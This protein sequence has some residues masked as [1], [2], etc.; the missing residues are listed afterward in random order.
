MME[1]QNQEKAT[2][3]QHVTVADAA[4]PETGNGKKEDKGGGKKEKKT[5]KPLT[6]KQ[7]QQRK[8]LM[9]YPLMGLLFLGS[10]WLIFAPS[11]KRDVNRDTVGAFN[12]DIPL[13][14]NDGIIGDKRKAYEQAQAEKQQAEK[15]RSLEDFAF[16]EES[17]TDG[18]EMELPDSEPEREPFR[19]YSDNGG[20]LVLRGTEGGRGKGGAEK[21]G[22][23][24]DR[25]TG[26]KGTAGGRN[27]RSGGADGEELRACRQVHG[28]ERAGRRSRAGARHRTGRQRFG[29]AR[30]GGAGGTGADG[31][32]AATAPE[33]CGVHA[34]VQPAKEL[35][36]QHGGRQRVRYGEEHDTGVHP[37]G[38]D[39]YGRTDGEAPAARTAASGKP[40]DSAEHARCGYGKGTGGTAG[41]RGVVH[42]IPGELAARGAGGV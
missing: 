38:S 8:K 13:P 7:L 30:R 40:C 18:V 14:E 25:Q 35:R 31:I 27:R 33:R 9:V 26:R 4:A 2:A 39:D 12:A 15:V 28:T 21:A 16:S 1:E 5:A 32:G 19:D 36:L 3:T 41:Y 29:T 34:A 37:R 17:D 20:R 11:E 22:G 42:R 23:G 10:M 6:P 24:A